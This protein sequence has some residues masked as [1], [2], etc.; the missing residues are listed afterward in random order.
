MDLAAPQKMERLPDYC[1]Q[2]DRY[3]ERWM[4][5]KFAYE[6]YEIIWLTI[7]YPQTIC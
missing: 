2:E 1:L 7:R 3:H 5:N 6:A 4:F